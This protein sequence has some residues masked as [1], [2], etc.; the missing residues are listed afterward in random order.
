MVWHVFVLALRT[1]VP[2]K[3]AIGIMRAFNL[4]IGPAL[5]MTG[6]DKVSVGPGRIRV[7]DDE[8]AVQYPAIAQSH[9]FGIAVLNQYLF[10][11]GV[12]FYFAAL[13]LNETCHAFDNA[14]CAT[15][16]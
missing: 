9:T 5:T 8:V 3:Q 4:A 11:L 7:G 10:N 1:E 2:H 12:A 16:R 6:V 13:A 14:A 15:H